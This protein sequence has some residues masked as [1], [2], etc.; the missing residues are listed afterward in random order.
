MNKTTTKS[1]GLGAGE[2]QTLHD[3]GRLLILPVAPGDEVFAVK[4]MT[5]PEANRAGAPTDKRNIVRMSNRPW[6][7][8][9]KVATISDCLTLWGNDVFPSEREAHAEADERNRR[10]YEGWEFE[11]KTEAQRRRP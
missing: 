11:R 10:V 4:R 8:V 3:S 2:V 6:K 1:Q 7:V 5:R 9:P